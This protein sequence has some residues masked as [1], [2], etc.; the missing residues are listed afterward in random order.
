MT[1][2]RFYHLTRQPLEQ[3]LGVILER[4][5]ARG[6]RAVVKFSDPDRLNHIDTVL[7]TADPNGFIPHGSKADGHAQDQPIWLTLSDE[8]PNQAK[9]LVLIDGVDTHNTESFDVICNIFDG[10]D[11]Q[12]VQVA[13]T[14]WKQNKSAGH[15]L[16]YWQQTPSGWQKAGS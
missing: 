7:W 4:V 13:R 8:N 3:A 2:I 15:D 5:L 6:D 10:N 1:E 14:R 12:A 9:I 11:P 16:T